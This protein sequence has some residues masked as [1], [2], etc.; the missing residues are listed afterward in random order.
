VR[1]GIRT[2]GQAMRIIPEAA[3]NCKTAEADIQRIIRLIQIFANPT[4]V[5]YYAG[6]SLIINRVE[7]F[8]EI[9]QAVLAYEKRD[10]KDLGYWI[11]E[12]MSTIFLKNQ[13]NIKGASKEILNFV[14]GFLEGIGSAS[15]FDQV[16]EC[17]DDSETVVED[18]TNGVEDIETKDPAKVKEGIQLLGK[19]V[20]II[21]DA[22]QL[23]KA[24][25]VD[26]ESL[27]KMVETFKNPISFLYH[28]GKSLVINH[29]EVFNEVSNAVTACNDK[30]YKQLGYWI[31]KAMDTI[32]LG[33]DVLSIAGLNVG[34]SQDYNRKIGILRKFGFLI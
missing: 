12:A 24:G 30:N 3:V 4:S 27:L 18:L 16:R 8:Y 32:L 31:G 29:V 28:I 17:I 11:G 25:E 2:L 23:C 33:Q 7:V 5:V 1:E 34:E 10:F 9:A 19:A 22:V 13:A 6:K 14:A 26:L 21:P 15:A 20:Q